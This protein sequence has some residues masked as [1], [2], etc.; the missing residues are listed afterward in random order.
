MASFKLPKQFRK[1]ERPDFVTLCVAA[2]D[3]ADKW[4]TFDFNSQIVTDFSADVYQELDQEGC[5][6]EEQDQVIRS[7][8]AKE[9]QELVKDFKDYGD[10]KLTPGDLM[11]LHAFLG[12]HQAWADCPQA[13]VYGVLLNDKQE[14]IQLGLFSLEQDY[15]T[16]DTKILVYEWFQKVKERFDQ[17]NRGLADGTYKIPKGGIA[18]FSTVESDGY[19]KI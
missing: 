9:V 2:N 6:K 10:T 13:T 11:F 4:F 17:I 5:P 3:Q 1:P 7:E 19:E 12:S 8:A 16:S 14:T 15:S 18:K